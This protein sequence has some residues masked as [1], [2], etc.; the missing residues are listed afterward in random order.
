MITYRTLAILLLLSLAAACSNS[1]GATEPPT[2]LPESTVKATTT[3]LADGSRVI[4]AAPI[5]QRSQPSG[6]QQLRLA[7]GALEPSTLD[8]ALLRDADASFIARQ[9]FRGLVSLDDELGVQPELAERIT[10]SPDGLRYEFRLRPALTFQDGAPL[11]AAAVVRSFERATDPGLAGGDGGR[12][13]AATYLDD[14][15]GVAE[16]LAGD[17]GAISGLTVLDGLSIQVE[18]VRPAANFL[19]KLAGSPAWVVD[20]QTATGEDWWRGPNGSGP[21]HV[22]EYQ[23]S[24]LLRLEPFD[25]YFSG[26][27]FLNSVEIRFGADAL[28]PLNLYEQGE[29][30]LTELPGYAI[31]RALSGTDYLGQD[32]RI[33]PQ[34]ATTY[35]ALN[36]NAEPYDDAELRAALGLLV[37]RERIVDVGL[38]GRA[39][40]AEGLVPDGILGRSWPAEL[41]PYDPDAARTSLA[42]AGQLSEAAQLFDPGGGS[43]VLLSEVAAQ[44]LQLELQVVAQQWPEFVGALTARELPAFALT[45]IADYADPASFLT[46]LFASNSSDNYLSYANPEVDE[47][48]AAAA[49][50]A[51]EQRRADLYLQAQQIIIDDGVLIPLYHGVVYMV[52]Q[53]QVQGLVVSPI[54]ILTL[55]NVWIAS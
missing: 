13:P 52:V 34:L 33:V 12:L 30:D 45:W 48:L 42:A 19:A 27:P 35:I 20:S 18:L 49:V 11:D 17:A 1:G 31:D 16:R 32:L 46:A 25:A 44:E 7:G 47:L 4:E 24:R 10:I 26:R 40:P 38:A 43:A 9:L 53:P 54:G 22:A 37:D 23:S 41:P 29:L 28:Q 39:S 8:P 15:V 3:E 14:I 5:P 55:E 36:P 6:D 51:D 50:E 21:F 2:P